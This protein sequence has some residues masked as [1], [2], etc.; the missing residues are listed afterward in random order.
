MAR[1]T[2][3]GDVMY[4]TVHCIVWADPICDRVAGIL[5]FLVI[6]I[7]HFLKLIEQDN[8]RLFNVLHE[9]IKLIASPWLIDHNGWKWE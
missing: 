5:I 8:A 9:L 3:H 6:T 7:I 4:V 1:H 2:D